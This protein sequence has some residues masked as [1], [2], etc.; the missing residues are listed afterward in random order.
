MILEE[1]FVDLTKVRVHSA[2]VMY[3]VCVFL[4]CFCFV[5]VLDR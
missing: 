4:F 3:I 2:A 5:I 1:N